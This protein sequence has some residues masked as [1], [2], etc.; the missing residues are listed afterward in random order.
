MSNRSTV[1]RYLR[2]NISHFREIQRNTKVPIDTLRSILNDLVQE[3]TVFK[4]NDGNK[5]FY[6]HRDNMKSYNI[7]EMNEI[8]NVL[9]TMCPP[10]KPIFEQFNM[11][12]LQQNLDTVTPQFFKEITPIVEKYFEKYKKKKIEKETSEKLKRE[13]KPL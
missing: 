1:E 2:N 10:L 8:M 3:G 5:D 12:E 13:L 4:N 9:T 7:K 11:G 6:I